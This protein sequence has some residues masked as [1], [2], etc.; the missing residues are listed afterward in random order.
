MPLFVEKRD[1][2]LTNPPAWLVESL[3][4]STYSGESVTVDRALTVP[5][6]LA[7][8]S[9]LTEDTSSLPL[10]LYHRLARGKE[11]A[12]DHPLYR[13][14]HDEP[15]PE[16]TSMV[17]REIVMGHLLGWGNHFSQLIYD[18]RG[19][20]REIWPLNPANMEIGRKDGERIYL[21]RNMQGKQIAFTQDQILHIPAMSFDGLR[22]Y[23]RIAL[24]R[25]AIALGMAAEKYASRVFQNDARPSVAVKHPNKLDDESHRH[26]RE[27]WTQ[28]YA[29][30]DNAGKVAILEEGMSLETIGFPPKDAMF[31]ESQSWTVQQLSRVFRI[32]NHMLGDVERSTSWGSGIEQQEMG[33]TTHTLR[34]WTTRIDQHLTSRLLLEQE[35]GEYFFEH[36]F[37]ALLRADT[38]TRMQAYAV[39]ITNGILTRNEVREAENRVPYEGGDEPLYPLNMTTSVDA[40]DHKEDEPAQDEEPKQDQPKRD[41]TPLLLDAARRIAKRDENELNGALKRYEGKPEKWTAWIEEFYK[42]DLPAF[43]LSTLKPFVDA[44]LL[45][46]EAIAGLAEGIGNKRGETVISKNYDIPDVD[47]LVNLLNQLQEAHHA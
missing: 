1:V 31:I 23:S 15:N 6:V 33:Y 13:L 26:L 20:V 43:I 3:S 17:W 32:P 42:R 47:I 41:L 35:K 27:S 18:A 45:N 37:D 9:I 12:V 11:R 4:L 22:G 24:A 29:G 38:L 19:I 8:F 46:R 40:E 25:N 44:D 10:I 16:M 28:A 34:P 5:A 2:S 7:G 14:I 39:A 36:N 30:A 21:Y